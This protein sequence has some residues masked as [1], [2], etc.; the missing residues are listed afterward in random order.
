MLFHYAILALVYGPKKTN[1]FLLYIYLYFS[2]MCADVH[3]EINGSCDNLR[4]DCWRWEINFIT[5]AL[6]SR[7]YP[8]LHHQPITARRAVYIIIAEVAISR[9]SLR[10][11]IMVNP[12][13][14]RNNKGS[15][16]ITGDGVLVIIARTCRRKRKRS[17]RAFL[18]PVPPCGHTCADARGKRRMNT[19]DS[20]NA[21]L[22]ATI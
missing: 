22:H 7:H 2:K 8:R 9:S 12:A 14:A 17:S 10:R 15:S 5:F 19:D 6:R 21:A 3:F 13:A 16:D 11:S 20:F 4:R 1:F 18:P